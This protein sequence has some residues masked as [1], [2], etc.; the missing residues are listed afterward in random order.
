LV[1]GWAERLPNEHAMSIK[2]RSDRHIEMKLL[3][4]RWWDV[5][6]LIP[7][8]LVTLLFLV[9]RQ[10]VQATVLLAIGALVL[11]WRAEIVERNVAGGHARVRGWVLVVQWLAMGS[12]YAV[13]VGVFWVASRSHW[14]RTR[15]GL[16]AV[17][18]CV[19]LAFFL[20]REMMQRGDKAFDYLSGSD[21]EVRVAHALEG[22]RERGWDIVHDVKR[23][24]GG[25]VDHLVLAPNIAFAIETKS[26]RDAA[27][28]RGQALSNAAWA[29]QKYGRPWVNAVLCVFTEPPTS[30]KKVG[31][32][33]V[34]SVDD[35]EPLL[36]R[37]AGAG[38]TSRA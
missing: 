10:F 16:V 31:Q 35:L 7:I 9:A 17:Y 29:K 15:P 37:L 12:I 8:A 5:A 23:D 28:A 21:A 26:G 13:I 2:R 27:R 6:L 22:F 30:P 33:W 32:A 24:W 25:N 19:G 36:N 11:V 3:Q 14:T 38:S 34:T 1:E 4:F 20:A 18:A